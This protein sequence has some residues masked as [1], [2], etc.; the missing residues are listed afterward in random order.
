MQNM[1]RSLDK[2]AEFLSNKFIAS[3]PIATQINPATVRIQRDLD[4]SLVHA[5]MDVLQPRSVSIARLINTSKGARWWISAR[6]RA[7]DIIA[8]GE[9]EKD[10]PENMGAPNAHPS[11]IEALLSPEPIVHAT[12]MGQQGAGLITTI[13]LVCETHGPA[14]VEIETSAQIITQDQ[15]LITA[16]LRSYRQMGTL[17]SHPSR[18]V[19][20]GLMNQTALEETFEYYGLFKTGLPIFMEENEVV[21]PTFVFE[22]D[23]DRRNPPQKPIF[24]MGLIDIDRFKEINSFY[25]CESGDRVLML[26]VRI[27]H[28]TFRHR[29]RFFRLGADEIT[30]IIRCSSADDAMTAFTRFRSQ[31]N[32]FF[33][34][35][36]GFITMSIGLTQIRTV[37]TASSALSRAQKAVDEGKEGGRDQVVS[38]DLSFVDSQ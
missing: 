17:V 10:S 28:N 8:M 33:F 14:V 4:A 24:W 6:M 31:L 22:G 26:I 1:D 34:P 32:K 13:E 3:V 9:S 38:L 37:D 12:L 21:T 18:D 30:I 25:G 29:D 27:L 11:R 2:S 15:R 19:T 7:G 16:I 23:M 36:V 20:T 35:N 5:L